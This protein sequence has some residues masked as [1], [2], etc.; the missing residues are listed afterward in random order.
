M[1]DCHLFC[2]FIV[3]NLNLFLS[4]VVSSVDCVE[5]GPTGCRG[6]HL[7]SLYVAEIWSNTDPFA[8]ELQHRAELGTSCCNLLYVVG[9]GD[10]SVIAS[11]LLNVVG[12]DSLVHC[13]GAQQSDS[14][15]CAV[16]QQHHLLLLAV[17]LNH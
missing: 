8:G 9:S 13:G 12:S 4:E 6:L 15:G 1:V 5:Y 14:V 7:H 11:G 17:G 3:H 10:D 16:V 2:F